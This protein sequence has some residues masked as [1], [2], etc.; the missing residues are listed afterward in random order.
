MFSDLN[1][2]LSSDNKLNTLIRLN[3]LHQMI[4]KPTRITPHFATLLDVLITDRPDTFLN[5]DVIPG[6]IADHDII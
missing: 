4:D 3:N 6:H 2:M 5:K 1:D